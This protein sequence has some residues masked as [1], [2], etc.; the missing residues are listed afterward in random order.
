MFAHTLGWR[1]DISVRSTSTKSIT[2]LTKWKAE[3]RLDTNVA[4]GQGGDED[5]PGW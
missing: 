4:R 3:G 1:V 5:A 2:S